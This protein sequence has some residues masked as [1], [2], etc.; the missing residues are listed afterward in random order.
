MAAAAISATSP[1][2]VDDIYATCQR[3]M[4]AGVTINRP[5]RDGHMAFVRS[6]DDI[7]IELL[8]EGAALP[9]AEP[10]ASMPNIGHMVGWPDRRFPTSSGRELPIV[11]APMAGAGGVALASPAMRGGA[12]GLAALCYAVARQVRDQVARFAPVTA[13]VQPQLL[14]PRHAGAAPTTAHWRALLAPYY[15]EF[16]VDPGDGAARC[17]CLRRA[18]CASVEALR[19]PV[20]SFHFGL[21]ATGLLA[22]VKAS[23]AVVFGNATTVAEA[24]WLEERG[25]DAIIAQGCEAGG[26]PGASS[27]RSGRASGPVRAAAAARRC[28]RPSP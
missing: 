11:Q 3:L 6:P 17:A 24:R 21:P 10:W 4:E 8:Q 23:G 15:D 7:S 2:E 20:V 18:M 5:P 25:V 19:P 1:I 14:L 13:P 28:G 9:P 27:D 12:L 16:G 22:R 26:H